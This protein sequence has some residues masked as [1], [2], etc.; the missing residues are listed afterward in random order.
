MARLRVLGSGKV[1][2]VPKTPRSQARLTTAEAPDGGRCYV[3]GGLA[4]FVAKLLHTAAA[5]A[6]TYRFIGSH[7]IDSI[8]AIG[9]ANRAMEEC[10]AHIIFLC[11]D[12]SAN[13]LVGQED[14]WKIG[15]S[16]EY[17]PR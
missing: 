2:V 1:E 8:F 9:V 10:K 3:L 6:D 12:S 15:S 7:D 5:E 17:L 11:Y 14:C 16:V 4:D 13:H